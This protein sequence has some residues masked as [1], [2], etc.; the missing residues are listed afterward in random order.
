MK[1]ALLAGALAA[2]GC[3][4][5][6]INGMEITPER[7]VTGLF[8]AI[9]AGTLIYALA[10]EDEGRGG[11]RTNPGFIVAPANIDDGGG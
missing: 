1:H 9:L 5:V 6:S 11:V 4:T 7:Q 10:E 2:S 8:T 3:S